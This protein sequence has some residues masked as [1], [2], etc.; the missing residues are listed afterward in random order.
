MR[1]LLRYIIIGTAVCVA[2]L[3]ASCGEY[4]RSIAATNHYT[5]EKAVMATYIMDFAY[6]SSSDLRYMQ[7]NYTSPR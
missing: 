3:I 4:G 6:D 7:S 2:A 5:V 1:S